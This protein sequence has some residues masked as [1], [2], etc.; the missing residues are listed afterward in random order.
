MVETERLKPGPIQHDELSPDLVARI[1]AIH[2][3][4]NVVLPRSLAE[5][6]DDFR[7]DANPEREVEVWERIVLVHRRV[8]E[9]AR[10]DTD[11]R[12]DLL[13]VLVGL[14]MGLEP[15]DLLRQ[16]PEVNR[17]LVQIAAA[18]FAR[19]SG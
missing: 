17:N 9:E 2:A 12:R 11:D 1:T 6:M 13:A 4:I 7:R 15:G 8:S 5:R 16:R 18:A 10:L 3:E 14:S 19:A